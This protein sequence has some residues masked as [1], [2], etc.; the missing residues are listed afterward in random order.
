MVQS[1]LDVMIEDGDYF[2]FSLAPNNRVT[3][4]RADIGHDALNMLTANM[5]RIRSSSTTEEQYSIAVEKFSKNPI[6]AGPMLNWV[7]RGRSVEI[8][9]E[10][11]GSALKMCPPGSV[12]SAYF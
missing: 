4:F 9:I 2:L 10:N 11:G 1:V 12:F 8:S 6:P 5:S 3:A 7:C